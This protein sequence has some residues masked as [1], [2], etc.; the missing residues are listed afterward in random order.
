MGAEENQSD[1]KGAKRH[2]GGVPPVGGSHTPVVVPRCERVNL[3]APSFWDCL[4]WR[5][6]HPKNPFNH[7]L[8]IRPDIP[9]FGTHNT[10]EVYLEKSV[11]IM[12]RVRAQLQLV[13]R[14]AD[15]FAR[16]ILGWRMVPC[17]WL[18]PPPD[19]RGGDVAAIRFLHESL[20]VAK[21]PV[22]TPELIRHHG[23]WCIAALV[24]ELD[25]IRMARLRWIEV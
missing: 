14:V 18:G 9:I 20:R 2:Q 17:V 4:A 11:A 6:P 16:T 7:P 25:G 1:K 12:E 5:E 23:E 15:L 8:P 19:P 21:L 10:S 3:Q 22:A 13:R 24:P